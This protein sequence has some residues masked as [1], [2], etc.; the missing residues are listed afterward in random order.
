M[1]LGV[2]GAV[3]LSHSTGADAAAN[4]VGTNLLAGFRP[5]VPGGLVEQPRGRGSKSEE[6]FHFR[7]EFTVKAIFAQKGVSLF[8]R[9]FER[10]M[11]ERFCLRPAIRIHT[12]RMLPMLTH[13]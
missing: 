6:R 10:S 8:V 9:N 13:I 2:G 7:P 12:G 11:V 4:P 3:D 5:A 1:Q